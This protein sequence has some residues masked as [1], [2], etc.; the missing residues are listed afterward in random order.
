MYFCLILVISFA[1]I[2]FLPVHCFYARA[3]WALAQTLGNILI[4]P[5]GL[6]RFRHFFLADVITSMVTPLQ[7]VGLIICFFEKDNWKLPTDDA[8]KF[9]YNYAHI[10]SFFPYWFRFMQCF[11]KY[12][13]TKLKVH[14]I[15]AGKYFSCILI[16]V[17]AFWQSSLGQ[18]LAVKLAATTYCFVWDLYMDWGLF[19]NLDSKSPNFLL[20]NKIMFPRW[21]YFYAIV[22]NLALRYL[23]LV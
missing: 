22:V 7:D 15:N 13:E 23:W 21:F 3:R 20:R 1:L 17:S 11:N 4:S 19:R 5:F 16:Q 9:T 12:H 14:L 10:I 18:F 6:V 2:C 8:C